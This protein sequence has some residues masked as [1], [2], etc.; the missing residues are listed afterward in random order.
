M[1]VLSVYEMKQ[2]P[3]RFEKQSLYI[4]GSIIDLVSNQPHESG[5]ITAEKK[6]FLQAKHTKI[7]GNLYHRLVKWHRQ[8]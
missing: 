1:D 3:P 6:S 8:L 5:L 4:A 7:H 2:T